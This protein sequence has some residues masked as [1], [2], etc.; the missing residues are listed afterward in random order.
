MKIPP[1]V[2]TTIGMVGGYAVAS[3]TRREYGGVIL[4]AAGAMAQV[5]WKR[6]LGWPVA[7]GLGA[8][9]TGAFGASHPLAKKLGA[10]PSVLTMAAG[11]A[12]ASLLARKLSTGT[13]SA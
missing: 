6:Q 3:N 11:V 4:A 9:Y 1:E 8:L 10:W 5:Q 2:F 7:A 13:L 12:G